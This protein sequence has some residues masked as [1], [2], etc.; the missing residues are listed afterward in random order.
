MASYYLDTSALVKRYAQEQGSAWAR[1]LA[2]PAAR[3]ALYTIRLTGP[4]LVAALARKA[5]TGEMT[6]ANASGAIQAFRADWDGRGRTLYRVLAAGPVATGRAM[7]LVVRHGLRGYDAAHLA[8]ALIVA[9]V[10]RR[11]GLPALTFVSADNGQR[12]AA[13][14]EGLPVD[15]PN[16]HP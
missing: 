9:D 16:A 15:D 11:R 14:A 6:A 10:R 7:D 1:A 13:A 8:A 2:D 3:H 4:E 12:Q 5:R